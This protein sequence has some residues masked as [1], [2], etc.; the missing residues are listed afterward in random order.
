MFSH[1]EMLAICMFPWKINSEPSPS[2]TMFFKFS[3]EKP[4][5][6]D[7]P[8]VAEKS[9]QKSYRPFGKTITTASFSA[10]CPRA[11]FITGITFRRLPGI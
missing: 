9:C 6:K 10:H 8:D 4:I 11:L 5:E 1:L 7:R 2:M 3:I